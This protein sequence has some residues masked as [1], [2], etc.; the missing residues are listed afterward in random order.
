MKIYLFLFC[1]LIAS[2]S[3]F[4]Q[5]NSPELKKKFPRLTISYNPVF[6]VQDYDISINNNVLRNS[7]TGEIVT[8]TV[9]PS[10]KSEKY[11]YTD[12]YTGHEFK[13][14]LLLAKW[15]EIGAGYHRF[16]SFVNLDLDAQ[17]FQTY[18][19]QGY[20]SYTAY[21]NLIFKYEPAFNS[22]LGYLKFYIPLIENKNEDTWK[23]FSLSFNPQ[24]SFSVNYSQ[25]SYSSYGIAL[26]VF[27]DSYTFNTDYPMNPIIY[28]YNFIAE[29]TP[30][31]EILHSKTNLFGLG[32]SFDC[33]KY[34]SLF[35]DF[36]YYV[37]F[38]KEELYI[39]SYY[40]EQGSSTGTHIRFP[41]T[42]TNMAAIKTGIAI[43]IPLR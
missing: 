6:F 14:G 4:P 36:S 21:E 38:K 11:C 33:L 19:V 15:F 1:L 8:T 25:Q 24:Y 37:S 40:F 28:D 32:I 23:H 26:P 20:G 7:S 17:V 9:D 2:N 35:V 42:I 18:N 5:V 31:E 34:V 22:L 3:I 30:T 13:I 41:G 27:P 29:Q 12:F 16:I 39:D 10:I 43:Q